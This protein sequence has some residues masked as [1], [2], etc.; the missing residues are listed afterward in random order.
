MMTGFSILSCGQ[1]PGQQKIGEFI[2]N[3]SFLMFFLLMI[4]Q[5]VK[6]QHREQDMSSGSTP[7][8]CKT[9]IVPSS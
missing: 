3:T 8:H 4:A 9:D 5:V 1:N 6:R 2:V 7:W